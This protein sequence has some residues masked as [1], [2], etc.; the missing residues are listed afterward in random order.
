MI[1]A[2]VKKIN[3]NKK[4]AT[5]FKTLQQAKRSIVAT[6][7]MSLLKVKTVWGGILWVGWVGIPTLFMSI[8]HFRFNRMPTIDPFTIKI[9]F[10]PTKV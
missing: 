10:H 5:A 7:M 9:I 3:S 6:D 8:N 2:S 4:V 1:I